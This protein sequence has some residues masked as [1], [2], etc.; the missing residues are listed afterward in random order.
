[1]YVFGFFSAKKSLSSALVGGKK[2]KKV[3]FTII[4]K[5]NFYMTLILLFVIEIMMSLI[6]FLQLNIHLFSESCDNPNTYCQNL[7]LSI[8]LFNIGYIKY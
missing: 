1:M 5:C 4:L 3:K 7:N 6:V 2:K 8:H